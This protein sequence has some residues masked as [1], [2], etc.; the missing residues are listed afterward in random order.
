MNWRTMPLDAIKASV[1]YS[2]VGGPFGSNLTTRDYVDE[3][4]PV[5]RGNNL[6][7]DASF[8]DDDFVFVSDKKADDLRSNTAFP[9]DLVFT[10][11]GTLGQVGVI[12]RDSGFQRYIIS[13]SQMKLTVDLEI[14]DPRFVYYFFRLPTTVQKVVSHALISG[15]PHINLGILK[16]FEIRIPEVGCQH[17]IADILSAYDDLIENN[18]RRM[19]L[20]EE[21]ARQLYREWF[22]RLRFPGHEHTRITDGVP[23]GWERAPF[24]TAL[25]LQRGFDLPIQ[26]R[27]AG[28]VPIYGSTGVSGYHS[29]AKVGGPGVVTGRSGTLGEVHYVQEDFW[30]LNTALWVKEFR[31]VGPLFAVFL[32]RAMD[33]KQYNG[34]VSVPTLDRKTV[35]RTEIL[36]PR[37]TL[38]ALFDNF[39][40]PLF[41][42]INSLAAQVEKL[43]AARDLLLPRLMSSEIA[44]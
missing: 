41:R 33:L 13:Q 14:A 3:G 36:I 4:V 27:E 43:R 40:T 28:A 6:P 16:S 8:S 11:R 17:R 21:A 19:A 39:T 22:V 10:Q 15:V 18:R 24:E 38:L 30:P 35:H 26:D 42:Q 20:L 32:M 9:G 44:V 34:G 23:E 12:P 2:F 25:V 5:I 1:P 37:K 29:K 31:R 7:A